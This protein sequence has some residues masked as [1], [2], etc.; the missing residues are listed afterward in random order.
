MSP[1]SPEKNTKIL[2]ICWTLSG[3]LLLLA[4]AASI[5]LSSNFGYDFE[6]VDMPL[7]ALFL[8]LL[9]VTAPF[10][11]LPLLTQKTLSTFAH[12]NNRALAAKTLQTLFFSMLLVGVLARLLMAFSEPLMEDDYQRYL[13]DGALTA[14]GYNPYSF[15]PKSILEGTSGEPGLERLA[16]QSGKTLERVNHPAL[17]T[18]YPPVAQLGF[19][20]A[21]GL[22]PF[23]LMAWKLVAFACELVSLAL[24]LLLLKRQNLPALWVALYWWNPLV[25]KE[26]VNAGH[27]EVLLV[28]LIAW[29]PVGCHTPCPGSRRSFLL[30]LAVGVKIWPGLLLPLFLRPF[31]ATPQ[32]LMSRHCCSFTGLVGLMFWPVLMAG[33]DQSSGFVAYAESWR[34]NSALLPILE[35]IMAQFISS[36]PPLDFGPKTPALATRLSIAL[37]LAATAVF[38]AWRKPITARDFTN[39]TLFITAI[40]F[41][42]SPAQLPWYAVWFIPF[43]VFY[44]LYGLALLTPLLQFYYLSFYIA[45]NDITGIVANMIVWLIWLPVWLVLAFEVR[46]ILS[47]RGEAL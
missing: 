9:A 37:A 4:C 10:V 8:S 30:A 22:K 29:V 6:V 18:I 40:L 35:A 5:P 33:L 19:A 2:L 24:L 26:L 34:T 15:S 31:L 23:S 7:L 47:R 3:G 16:E 25:I 39:Y 27:M 43:M 41:L 20:L 45:A 28:P 44:P 14:N 1:V 32:K 17:R 11:A 21:Y 42:L 12:L 36:I 38:A 46:K 13:W